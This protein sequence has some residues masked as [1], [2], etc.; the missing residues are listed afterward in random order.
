MKRAVLGFASLIL[1]ATLLVGCGPTPAP[2]P[3]AT[4]YPTYTPYPTPTP[5]PPTPT[6][7]PTDTPVPTAT[8]EP[9]DT[10]APEPTDTPI[11][12]P[13]DTPVPTDTPIPE[14]PTATPAAGP[15]ILFRDDFEGVLAIGWGWV[16]EDPTHWNLTDVSGS[17]RIILQPGGLNTANNLLLREAP[18]GNFEM[19]TL[20]RFTPTSNFQFA[21]LLI[22]QDDSNAI[23]FG[24]A[25]CNAPDVCVG[26]GIYFDN[27]QHG[28]F[29]GSNYATATANP[30]QAYLRLR[31]EG[32][33]YTGYHS[34]DG[35]NWTVIGQHTS[36]LTP[37][38]V[39]LIAAQ[40]SEAEITADFDY[41][42]IEALP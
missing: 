36:N 18:A 5:M 8:P 9:T 41:F 26:N 16:R 23:Q 10:P 31:R 30:S 34:E 25:F 20:V 28:E 24:R 11:P 42:T 37:L 3:T 15:A 22:Y 14:P 1:I 4:P 27:I 39:G 17:V 6:P 19:A 35:T 38:R 29:S 32:T 40:A 12:E 2:P 21:G 13:T 7:A 33:T